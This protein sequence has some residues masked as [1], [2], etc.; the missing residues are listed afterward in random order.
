MKSCFAAVSNLLAAAF[1][2]L[3]ILAASLIIVVFIADLQ[4]F[5]AASYRRAMLDQHVYE[6]MPA[7]A[8]EQI[9]YQA[10][11]PTSSA[12]LAPELKRLSQP[13]WEYLISQVLT[14]EAMRV[15]TENVIDQ[16]F[17]YLAPPYT[18]IYASVDTSPKPL[19][20]KISLVD[21]KQN[22]DSQTG[23]NAILHIINQQPACTAQEWEQLVNSVQTAQFENIPFCHPPADVLTIAE[24]Y[25][26]TALHDLTATIPNEVHLEGRNISASGSAR[27][28]EFRLTYRRV[29]RW[30]G[31]SLCLPLILLA[32]TAVFGVRSLTGC[33]LWLGLPLAVTGLFT[34]VAALVTWR[35]PGWASS[36]ASGGHLTAEGV[37]PGLTQALVDVATYIVHAAART[38]GVVGILMVLLGGGLLVA[39]LLFGTARRHW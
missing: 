6:R 1:A 24:P 16:F 29:R 10:D 38:M 35:L 25:L 26:R 22:L 7:L 9:I 39:G 2:I 21:F 20:L 32:L 3:F 15:Q 30:I 12:S 31:L 5:N 36:T 27:L 13:D 17:T 11:H 19:D 34:F 18:L 4:L 33:G 14:T 37:A 23:Y 28:D 8:A